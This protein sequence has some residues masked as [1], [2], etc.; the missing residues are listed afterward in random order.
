M[1]F[2]FLTKSFKDFWKQYNETEKC[3]L[4][5]ILVIQGRLGLVWLS[6]LQQAVTAAIHLI[7]EYLKGAAVYNS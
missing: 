6:F 1:L 5:I 7:L 4:K 3:I 2:D